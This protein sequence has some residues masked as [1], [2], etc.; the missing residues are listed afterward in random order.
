MWLSYF[1]GNIK[2]FPVVFTVKVELSVLYFID[3]M[4]D[5]TIT[6]SE[7]AITDKSAQS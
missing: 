4:T 5:S 1:S 7:K 3:F 2:S 6:F